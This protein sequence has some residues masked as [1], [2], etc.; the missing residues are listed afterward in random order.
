MSPHP[1]SLAA[2][3][4]AL[5]LAACRSVG[6]DYQSPPDIS[7]PAFSQ[8]DP[9]PT[10]DLTRWW[11][12]FKDPKLDSL[13]SRAF[14]AN[15]D[16]RSAAARIDEARASRRSASAAFAP[17]LD[18]SAS[19]TRQKLSENSPTGRNIP[20]PGLFDPQSQLDL[21]IDASWEI[22]FFGG[23]RRASEAASASL[24]AAVE[25]LRA[26]KVS[27]S[28]ETAA[29][30][31]EL[32][33]YQAR[34]LV[35]EQNLKSQR[36]TLTL[37]SQRLAAGLAT[38][39]DVAR[40]EQQAEATAAS[41][42]IFEAGARRSIYRLGVLL[43]TT[44]ADLVPDLTSPKPLPSH[45]RGVPVGLPSDLL[46]RRPDIRRAERE[47]AAANARIGV[48]IANL[49]P[50]FRLTSASGLQSVEASSLFNNQSNLWSLGPSLSW[51][52]FNAGQL[53]AAADAQSANTRAA[54]ANYEKTVLSALED[55]ESA[56]VDFGQEQRRL[57]S[58]T[59]SAAAASRARNLARDRHLAGLTGFIDVLEADRAL[60]LTEDDCVQ[61]RTQLT[62]NL[63]RLYKALGGGWQD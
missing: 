9:S 43:G 19:A 62:L 34:R 23:L 44:P 35:A 33:G 59:N 8:G 61:S 40:A 39:L 60:L 55:V 37:T 28:A 32:R 10:K 2:V 38:D 52:I 24:D 14:S 26:V 49:Y 4:A 31:F 48:A 46:L 58:L 12:D 27:L 53:R 21:R 63:V 45:L 16:L 15:P 7:G 54:A 3:A 56:L 17:Q 11:H 5:S 57:A 51:P 41:L 42:P 18:G 13:I 6:P 47:L 25:N 50:R 36:D 29:A 1:A 20:I 30:Y 22:D